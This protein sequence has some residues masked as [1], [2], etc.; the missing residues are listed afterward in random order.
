MY[1]RPIDNF[2]VTGGI[3]AAV[4]LVAV[5]A[6]VL[7][8]A[9][10]RPYLAVGWLW[11]VG[12]L[13]PVLGL[14]QVGI[15]THAD[16]YTYVP[17]IGLFVMLVWGLAELAANRVPAPG[18]AAAAGVALL[19]CLIATH[20]QAALW[21]DN[22]K[23]WKHAVAA[24]ENNF[25]AHDNL[26]VA[27]M[28]RERF[29]DAEKQFRKA[30]EV[31]PK[32]A[33]GHYHLGRALAARERYAE[34]IGHLI[35]AT[36][37]APALAPAYPELGSCRMSM[38]DME[39]AIAPLREAVRLAPDA[40]LA[41]CNLGTAL[42]YRGRTEEAAREAAAAVRLDPALPEAHKLRGMA[43]AVAGRPVEA[44]AEFRA[45]LAGGDPGAP[46]F[47][48]WC[49]TTEGRREE[50]RDQY[51]A[52]VLRLASWL[53]R[54]HKEAWWLATNPDPSRRNGPF[55]LLWAQT[56]AQAVED[57]EPA[58]LDALAAALAECGRFD[59]AAAA[60]RKAQGL[61]QG[62]LAEQIGRRLKM[63]EDHK[64]FHEGGSEK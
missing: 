14:V 32:F 37:I 20:I 49:L 55:A 41:H 40:A 51:R 24:T 53:P 16:R 1:T 39:G 9:K 5:T 54:A 15:Q 8:Q 59:E 26:G 7:W 52:A 62:E 64:P 18:L 58:A 44:E 28:A 6:L 17:H 22:V 10:R 50:A 29:A 27:L 33:V 63:Y 57:R 36:R 43:E 34:A 61:A 38:G 45:A 12:T 46:F 31:E 4:L 2:P 11:F 19:A 30:V 48:G 23:L 35:E 60:A 3:A 42:L 13:L 56:V 47:L 21:A 25:G